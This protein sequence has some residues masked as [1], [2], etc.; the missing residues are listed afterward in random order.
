MKFGP[1]LL[2]LHAQT[3][4]FLHTSTVHLLKPLKLKVVENL[5][6]IRVC[7]PIE[8]NA[9]FPMIF[10]KVFRPSFFSSSFCA[11]FF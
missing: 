6:E 5:N 3:S 11:L 10:L 4:P 8:Q 7:A 9:P 1:G 2:F